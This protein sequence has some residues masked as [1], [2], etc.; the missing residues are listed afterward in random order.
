MR[1]VV[2]R[3]LHASSTVNGK[4]TGKIDKGLLLFVGFKESDTEDDVIKLANKVSKLRIFSD[5]NNKMNLSLNDVSG[6]ILSISQFT[7]YGSL[8]KTN[9]PSFSS[10]MGF[11]KAK[12]FYKMF[13]NV[14][15][16]DHE[17]TVSEGI[18]GEDMKIELNNDG[19]VTI[20]LDSETL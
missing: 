4:I 10:S 17:L 9:R 12:Q 15:R 7:L 2:Q 14:L 8:K 18:F 3:V 16:T 1:I 13:N 6:S 19:P 11:N 5:S 20:I